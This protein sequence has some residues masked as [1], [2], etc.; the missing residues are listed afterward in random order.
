MRERTRGSILARLAKLEA[1]V[2][3]RPRSPW[4]LP[5]GQ[6]FFLHYLCE[7]YAE[8][9]AI[10]P[11][12]R[13]LLAALAECCAVFPE[14]EEADLAAPALASR[15]WALRQELLAFLDAHLDTDHRSWRYS[16]AWTEL[17]LAGF[18]A[19]LGQRER[20]PTAQQWCEG[21]SDLEVVF[22][23][24]DCLVRAEGRAQSWRY[25]LYLRGSGRELWES[26]RLPEEEEAILLAEL[27]ADTPEKRAA[28]AE[29]E[30]E[31]WLSGSPR[32]VA[33]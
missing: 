29:A 24:A 11:S 27:G 33:T 31:R 4:S 14:Y 32:E 9:G 20:G 13:A 15:L 3:K 28:I 5:A 10:I 6:S 8:P 19:R 25:W 23:T 12:A 16:M 18:G 30:R 2:A 21:L 1:A 7:Q 17:A 26:V 22:E